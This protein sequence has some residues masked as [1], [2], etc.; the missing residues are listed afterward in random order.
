MSDWRSSKLAF[1]YAR[2]NTNPPFLLPSFRNQCGLGDRVSW[3]VCSRGRGGPWL[4][5]REPC[6]RITGPLSLRA[7]EKPVGV[8]IVIVSKGLDDLEE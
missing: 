6:L 8:W 7:R 5:G 3:V 2:A 4:T 1:P